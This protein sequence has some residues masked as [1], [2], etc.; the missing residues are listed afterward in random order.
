MKATGTWAYKRPR[1]FRL[2]IGIG[3]TIVRFAI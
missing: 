3:K 2:T 1:G